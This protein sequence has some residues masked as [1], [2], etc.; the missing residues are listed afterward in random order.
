MYSVTKE[1]CLQF[2][3]DEQGTIVATQRS[4]ANLLARKN[5]NCCART[6]TRKQNAGVDSSNKAVPEVLSIGVSRKFDAFSSLG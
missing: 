1:L 6:P 3:A 5:G 2:P 4:L